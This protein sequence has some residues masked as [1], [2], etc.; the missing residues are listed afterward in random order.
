MEV[1][2]LQRG[3]TPKLKVLWPRINI[4]GLKNLNLP[5]IVLSAARKATEPQ[6]AG[7]RV[8]C[9]L[10]LCFQAKTT[11]KKKNQFPNRET[12]FAKECLWL[13][14]WFQFG[15]HSWCLMFCCYGCNAAALLMQVQCSCNLSAQF[16]SSYHLLGHLMRLVQLNLQW[17]LIL[18]APLCRQI[19]LLPLICLYICMLCPSLQ[20][21]T[22]AVLG[23]LEAAM[24]PIWYQMLLKTPRLVVWA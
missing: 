9:S 18:L 15:V 10:C 1:A 7:I 4:L 12:D 14:I 16:P 21:S 20:I 6:T 5:A 13:L 19:L 17:N 11:Q 22:S 3:K 2:Q 8:I 23:V 24:H